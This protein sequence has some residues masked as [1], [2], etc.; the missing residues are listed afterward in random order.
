MTTHPRPLV[1]GHRGASADHPENTRDAFAGAVEQ[2]ADG[3]ELDVRINRLG[4]L[5]V[6]HDAWYRDGRTLWEVELSA[7]P[8]GTCDL[9]AALEV[10]VGLLVNVE[11]KNDP[12][13]V[14]GDH[15]PHSLEV[16]DAVVDLLAARGGTDR[17]VVS[18]FDAPT[19]ARVVE[20]APGLPTGFLVPDPRS[21]PD[22][23]ERV[24]AAGHVAVHP[25]E[26]CVDA[27]LVE[28]CGR[29]GLAVNTWTVD[30]PARAR[31]LAALGVHC[32]ITNRPAVILEALTP[33]PDATA[34]DGR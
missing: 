22:L 18:S 14:G 1:L 24:A 25:W 4:E 30:D 31:E 33:P 21:S 34:P 17:V 3:V 27:E 29:S 20:C 12:S 26:A 5:I 23:V 13:D 8:E 32:V 10:C 2:G 7:A 15:V 28:R 9:A 6:H 11:I 19:L 16:A